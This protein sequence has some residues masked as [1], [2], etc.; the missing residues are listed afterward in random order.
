MTRIQ[1][2]KKRWRWAGPSRSASFW[3]RSGRSQAAK[4]LASGSKGQAGAL[5]LTLEPL[6]SV[7]PDLAGVGEVATDLDEPRSEL[8]VEDVEVVDGDRPVSLVEAKVDRVAV[9]S[10]ASGI[11]HEDL[12]DFLGCHDGDDPGSAVLVGRL[13]IGTDVVELAVV[14]AGAVRS[15][16]SEQGDVVGLGEGLDV[17]R[18]RSPIFLNSAGEGMSCPRCWVKKVTTDH[19][20]GDWARRR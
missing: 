18:K 9:L 13:Q 4:P 2:L 17:L 1:R 16:K 19:P 14:P 5:G 6:V 8:G 12:L 7:Q 3:S 11:A 20:P 15:V 10:L